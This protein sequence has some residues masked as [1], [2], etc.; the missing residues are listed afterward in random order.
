MNK[1]S[2]IESSICSLSPGL[3]GQANTLVN[4]TD[5]RNMRLA[6]FAAEYWQHIGFFNKVPYFAAKFARRIFRV[7]VLF[8]RVF[9]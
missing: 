7:S 8:T 6:K 5:T 1:K 9:A 4:R 3:E 2:K